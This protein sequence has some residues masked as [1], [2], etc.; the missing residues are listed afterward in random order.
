MPSV[1]APAILA[2][3]PEE[4][5]AQIALVHTFAQRLHIDL[6]DGTFAPSQTVQVQQAWWPQEWMVDIHAMVA[7]PELYVDQLIALK[8]H[9][10]IFHVEV[11]TD[12]VP[13]LQKLKA[14]GVKAGVAVMRPTVPADIAPILEA[15][16]HAM[17]FSGDLGKYGGTASLMQLEK[18][19]LI[20]AI[21]A[22]LEIGW[23]G[24]VS[25]DNAYSLSQ[26]G[27]DVLYVGGAI[28]KADDPQAAY[29][30]LV[31]EINKQGV[32]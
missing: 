18:V 20:K 9:M 29:A 11:Q 27:V 2:A 26:G 32:I 3:T 1:I 19:R 31:E 28:Q 13:V 22:G 7:Q 12:L 30:K 16:D 15:T 25:V 6:S 23:D 8:P 10:V 21:N 24:G 5:K 17:I 14:A 4:Y